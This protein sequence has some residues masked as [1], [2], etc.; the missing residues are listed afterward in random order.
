MLTA[1]RRSFLFRRGTLSE[2]INTPFPQTAILP[3]V[4]L[5]RA[6]AINSLTNSLTI[7]FFSC[8]L[9]FTAWVMVRVI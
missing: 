7:L 3:R 4:V 6:S 9:S 8:G 2:K 1:P 5:M